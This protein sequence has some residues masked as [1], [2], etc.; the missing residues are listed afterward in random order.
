MDTTVSYSYDELI[1]VTFKVPRNALDA[2]KLAIWLFAFT[3]VAA[4]GRVKAVFG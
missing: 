4:C 2:F 3:G 1:V